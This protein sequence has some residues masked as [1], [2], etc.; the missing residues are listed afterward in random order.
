MPLNVVAEITI[1]VYRK[2][3][4]HINV[5]MKKVKCIENPQFCNNSN[6]K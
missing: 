6:I 2:L 1:L 5:I 3:L 4:M